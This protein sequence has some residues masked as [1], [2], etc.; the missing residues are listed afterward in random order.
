MSSSNH[1]TVTPVPG[2]PPDNNR[3]GPARPPSLGIIFGW[4][5]LALVIIA[6]AGAAWFQQLRKQR[7]SPPP[8]VLGKVSA[9]QFVDERGTT[10][11]VSSLDG[12]IWVVD[13][14]FTRCG[15]QCPL[16]TMNMRN[17][18]TW[19]DENH[20]GNVRLVSVTVDPE[21]DTPDVLFKYARTFKAVE[22]RWHFLTGDRKTI[23]DFIL[24]DFKLATEEEKNQPPAE[25]F[26]HSD[27]LVLIDKDRNIRGY[28][29]GTE[30]KND[31]TNEMESL[32]N[33]IISLSQQPS[34]SS[35]EGR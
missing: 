15:G 24:N 19:L 12:R 20:F 4:I 23:Y 31:T 21:H 9:P 18:Q 26:V 5:I 29:S 13:F 17:L 22:G 6:I 27:K 30:A 34:L 35:T 33:A 2:N 16:M 14:I 3:P 7:V 32:R 11:P 25:M 28:Y 8:P 10:F 1:E